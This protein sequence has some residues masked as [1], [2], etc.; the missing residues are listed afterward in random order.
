MKNLA[1][2]AGL[3]LMLAG[4]ANHCS[5]GSSGMGFGV[6]PVMMSSARYRPCHDECL[7]PV[8]PKP[9]GCSRSCPCWGKHQ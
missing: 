7:D 9:C 4:C 8:D 3:V 1:S 5:D 2:V 6:G